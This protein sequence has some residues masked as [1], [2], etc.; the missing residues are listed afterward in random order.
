MRPNHLFLDQFGEPIWART[1]KE[2][3]EKDR[4]RPR[5]HDVPRQEGRQCCPLRLCHRPALV[6][7]FR[8]G[9]GAGVMAE[10][11][12]YVHPLPKH[13]SG[14]SRSRSTTGIGSTSEPPSPCR[15]IS[16]SVTALVY[17]A[18]FSLKGGR[19]V[20]IANVDPPQT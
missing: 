5:Q 18:M 7:P 6:H 10:Q 19:L 17:E 12:G 15:S 8:S 2:L 11:K 14:R 1:V 13:V 16:L 20:S 4:R 9:R 3:R